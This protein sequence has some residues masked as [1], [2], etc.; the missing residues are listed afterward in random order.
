MTY[1]SVVSR[2]SVRLDFLILVLN[3]L[4]ILVGNIHNEYLNALKKEKGLSTIAMSGNMIND[5]LLLLL[6]LSMV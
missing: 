4:Y 3:D 1:V 5:K 2:D 6:E